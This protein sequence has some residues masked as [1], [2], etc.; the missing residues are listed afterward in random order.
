MYGP[1][2]KCGKCLGGET[3]EKRGPVKLNELFRA[4]LAGSVD[5]GVTKARLIA[6]DQPIRPLPSAVYE[7]V[8]ERM[9]AG[10][11][12]HSVPAI[13]KLKIFLSYA[14]EHRQV[15]EKIHSWLVDLGHSVWLDV[16]EL[17]SAH[18][19]DSIIERA[20]E[21]RAFFVACLSKECVDEA[22][23]VFRELALALSRAK[24]SRYL[25]LIPIVV[26]A[27]GAPDD[28]TEFCPIVLSEPDSL[29]RLALT[30]EVGSKDYL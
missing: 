3:P 6:N 27:F 8:E 19:L 23:Y 5:G 30:L 28:L 15:A 13:Q 4:S 14:R 2:D 21:E 11:R 25:Y 20:I 22:R 24:T 16:Y 12:L 10:S 17:D 1:G 18:H 26:D 29:H 9:R 7:D